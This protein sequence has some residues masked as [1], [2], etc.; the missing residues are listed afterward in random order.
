M[1]HFRKKMLSFFLTTECNLACSYCFAQEERNNDTIPWE[2]AKLGVDYFITKQDYRHIRFSGGGEPTIKFDLMK[3]I[4]NYANSQT[5]DVLTSEIQT[6][7]L[8][9]H[10]VTKW[11]AKNMDI[12][13]ISCDGPPDIQNKYRPLKGNGKSS[14]IL[15]QNVKYLT[16]F[17]KGMTGVRTTITSDNLFRQDEMLEYYNSL[18]ISF[19]WSD[20]IFSAVSEEEQEN[21]EIDMMDYAREFIKAQKVAEK[22]EMVYGSILTC[23]FDEKII[24]HCRACLPTPHLTTD[25]YISACDMA[26]FG[27]SSHQR[28]DVFIYGKWD[29]INNKIV[30]DQKKID[31]LRS[32]NV[33]NMPCCTG[34]EA[35]YHCGGYCLGE[36]VNEEGSLFTK[37]G[38][39]CNAVRHLLKNY[40]PPKGGYPFLHP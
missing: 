38:T 20:P 4:Y 19:V 6:N 26:L 34:C 14:K 8:F 22:L 17:G 9:Q 2:F 39:V 25:G 1:A 13:W 27:E 24:Y 37:K 3:K 15:E 32:R 18:G 23:N 29:K 35:K 11:L 30:L 28:M 33:D 7:G 16:G 40:V 10:Q 36:T 12:I 5:E 31:Q 21:S